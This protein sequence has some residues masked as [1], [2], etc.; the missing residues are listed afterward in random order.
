MSASNGLNG[1]NWQGLFNWSTSHSDGTMPSVFT[2]MSKEESKW[3][4]DAIKSYTF[5]EVDRMKEILAI[6]HEHQIKDK[7][8]LIDVLEELHDIINVHERNSTNLDRIGGFKVLMDVMFNNPSAAVRKV[9][10]Q[11]FSSIVQNNKEMQ[12]IAHK[13]GGLHLLIQYINEEDSKLKEQVIGAFSSLIRTPVTSLKAEFFKEMNGLD[14]VKQIILEKNTSKKVLLKIYFFLYDLIVKETDKSIDTVLYKDSLI[15]DFIL[16][17]KKLAKR[18]LETIDYN[19]EDNLFS[20]HTLREFAL[21]V[22]GAIFQ[23]KNKALTKSFGQ[24]LLDKN[25]KISEEIENINNN[26]GDEDTAHLL[27]REQSIITSIL[28]NDGDFLL[29]A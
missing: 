9:A 18:I 8:E 3:L 20:D 5:D 2:A 1:I 14:W 13:Y 15:K 23:Y 28:E 16:K 11:T 7:D 17:D 6:I 26:G 25:S 12:E 10:L 24:S 4:Q 21:N 19:D 29:I 22:L 27:S